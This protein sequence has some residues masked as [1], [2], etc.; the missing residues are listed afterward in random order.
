MNHATLDDALAALDRLA[1]F[2]RLGGAPQD[3]DPLGRVRRALARDGDPH[4]RFRVLHVAGTNGKG[5]VAAMLASVLGKMGHTIG[6]YV[7]PHLVRVHERIVV[8]GGCISSGDLLAVLNRILP[9]AEAEGLT[10]FEAM[11]VA[12]LRHF[13]DR[14]VAAAVLEVGLGGRLDATNVAETAVTGIAPVGWDHMH[15]LGHTLGAIARE[16]G[17]IIK[18]GVPVVLAPQEP[19]VADVLRGMAGDRGAPLH[20]VGEDVV[21]E[22]EAGDRFAIRT[23]R[24]HHRGLEI[25]LRGIHQR[26]N[27]AL[28]VGMLEAFVEQKRRELSATAVSAGLREVSWPARIEVFPGEPSI[29]LDVAHNV[30]AARNLRRVLEEEMG[31]RR[32]VFVVGISRDKDRAGVLREFAP[33]A[34]SFIFPRRDHPRLAAPGELLPFVRD[35]GIPAEESSSVEEAMSRARALAS[36]EGRVVVTGSFFIAGEARAILKRS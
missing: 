5:S 7:S 3:G 28:A 26:T 35:L 21:V 11:T 14:D 29:I 17:G 19:E 27:A 4:R 10:W 24:G 13:A 18:P 2:E 1:D 25:L 34:S 32:A 9:A 30:P 16:K 23:W 20:I 33:L 12:A 22:A 31:I 36:P 8:G 6:L 15:V